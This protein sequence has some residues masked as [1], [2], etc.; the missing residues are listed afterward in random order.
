MASSLYVQI[1]A[2]LAV[3]STASAMAI[4]PEIPPMPYITLQNAA[5]A[6]VN[7]PA[8]GLGQGAS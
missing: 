8:I 5:R 3:A 1:L 7:F 6:N 2:A 4:A